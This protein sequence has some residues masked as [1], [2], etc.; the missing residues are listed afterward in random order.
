VTPSR[1]GKH[2]D[3]RDIH[4]AEGH[5]NLADGS[6]GASTVVNLKGHRHAAVIAELADAGA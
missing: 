5:R 6:V 3:A 1:P 4:Y 2:D